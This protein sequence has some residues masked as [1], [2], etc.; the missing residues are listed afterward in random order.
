MWSSDEYTDITQMPLLPYSV[1][2]IFNATNDVSLLE[3]FVPPLV[4]YYQWWA[5]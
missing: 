4:A 2:A 3:E 1:R 5:G